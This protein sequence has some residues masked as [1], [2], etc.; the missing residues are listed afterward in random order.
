[1][2][3]SSIHKVGT[4]ELSNPN[5]KKINSTNYSSHLSG[6]VLPFVFDHRTERKDLVS[7]KN[8]G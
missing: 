1:M 3:Y 2:N 8:P 7:R 6:F 4:Q 5:R